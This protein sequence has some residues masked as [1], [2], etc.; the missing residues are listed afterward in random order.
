MGKDHC[1]ICKRFRERYT[2]YPC[3]IC[4]ECCPTLPVKIILEILDITYHEA[5]SSTSY[6]TLPVTQSLDIN[7]PG[8]WITMNN[9]GKFQ[10]CGIMHNISIS[11]NKHVKHTDETDMMVLQ[12]YH[13]GE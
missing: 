11:L 4:V 3:K 13:N 2:S 7:S 9:E 5:I 10:R 12:S 8:L 6:I 1:S